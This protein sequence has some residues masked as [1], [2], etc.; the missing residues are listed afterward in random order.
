MDIQRIN[1]LLDE[2]KKQQAFRLLYEQDQDIQPYPIDW[3]RV[4]TPIEYDA[5]YTIRCLGIDLY[6]QYPIGK[7]FAD[8]AAP[9]QKFILECD[10]K[11]WHD[12]EKDA[13]RDLY[14]SHLG[15]Q[16]FRVTGSECHRPAIDFY[17]L[18]EDF[19]TAKITEQEYKNSI[20]D[21]ALNTSDGVISALANKYF[22]K[23][24]HADREEYFNET[25]IN[26]ETTRYL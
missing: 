15:W 3:T 18:L 11:E 8:F 26:H 5:W 25:L 2:G 7:Y 23:K 4:F 14:M 12:E 6:P 13:K 19:K 24:F 9:K 20:R 10:G 16:I 17:E 21:W 22:G 1:A